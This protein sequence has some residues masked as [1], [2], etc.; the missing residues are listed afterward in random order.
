[1]AVQSITGAILC[2]PLL[3]TNEFSNFAR[4]PRPIFKKINLA[5]VIKK[6]VEFIKMSSKNSISYFLMPLCSLPNWYLKK[7]QL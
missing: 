5:E 2:L 7:V 4:M 6:S 1:M 3:K